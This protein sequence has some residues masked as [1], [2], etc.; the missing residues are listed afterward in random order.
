[1]GITSKVDT[2]PE[3]L[4]SWV[5]PL[6]FLHDLIGPLH[7]VSD[8]RYGGW[9]K[10]VLVLGELSGG[11]NASGDQQSS[12]ASLIHL[13]TISLSLYIR[14]VEFLNLTL[15]PNGIQPNA[16][17]IAASKAIVAGKKE[18]LENLRAILKDVHK[19]QNSFGTRLFQGLKLRLGARIQKKAIVE[20]VEKQEKDAA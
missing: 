14:L 17:P 20:R 4:F 11:Q 6:N 5:L 10:L 1:M 19:P 9:A 8:S 7:A 18:E 13:P 12:F 2:V 16:L 15:S 3:K